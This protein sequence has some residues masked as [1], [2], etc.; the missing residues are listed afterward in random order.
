M[1]LT[2][3]NPYQALCE[4]FV[5]YSKSSSLFVY[6]KPNIFS[7]CDL[8]VS[9]PLFSHRRAWLTGLLPWFA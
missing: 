9:F 8:L 7:L 2:K 3:A 5:I 1:I 4:L 6:Q